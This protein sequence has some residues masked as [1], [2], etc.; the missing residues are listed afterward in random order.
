[1]KKGLLLFCSIFIFLASFLFYQLILFAEYLKEIP[2]IQAEK[3]TLIPGIMG[4]EDIV[5][6]NG[7]G[8]A[9]S[10][11]RIKLWHGGNINSTN[12]TPNGEIYAIYPSDSNKISFKLIPLKDFPEEVAFHPH[13]LSLYKNTLYAINHAYGKGG[14]RIEV[15]EITAEENE[16]KLSIAYKYSLKPQDKFKD[17]YGAFN[18]LLVINENEL[19]ISTW[20][21]VPH[22]IHGANIK[23]TFWLDLKRTL[24]ML[25]FKQTFIHYCKINEKKEISCKE[26]PQTA[27]QINN[28][29]AFDGKDLIMVAKSTEKKVS[30]YRL[31]DKDGEKDLSFL[32]DIDINY[33]VDNI[34]YYSETKTFYIGVLGRIMDFLLEEQM[35]EKKG[36]LEFEKDMKSGVI[37]VKIEEKIENMKAE[38]LYMQN[39][40]N[41]VSVG[42]R[43]KDYFLLGGPFFDGVSVCFI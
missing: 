29:I 14:E 23:E 16:D 21:S 39:E 25:L 4:P 31:I 3:C 33:V 28:G 2:L 40:L 19:F 1:M 41:S 32:R 36:K 38:I 18:D 5:N 12:E 10:D 15:F 11:N 34:E 7:I 30:L 22:T 27:S 26:L 13:G 24:Y 43:F 17:Y 20:L 42:C 8:L 35:M 37:A 6:W 9:G